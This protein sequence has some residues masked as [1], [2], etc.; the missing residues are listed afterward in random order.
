MKWNSFTPLILRS[1]NLLH[2]LMPE[3]CAFLEN[4]RSAELYR[5]RISRSGFTLPLTPQI[6]RSILRRFVIDYK[7]LALVETGTQYGDTPWHFRHE[8]SEIYSI[9]FHPGLA[10]I[11]RERFRCFPHIHIVE[12]D[13]GGKLVEILPKLE[14]K[15]L[16]WL[17]GHYSA[18]TTA[19]GKL[20]CPIYAELQSIFE[21]CRVPYVVLIDDARCFGVDKDYPTIQELESFVMKSGPQLAFGITN[22]VIF[23]IPQSA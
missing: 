14:K 22:D 4:V 3:L 1:R 10:A 23:I 2:F 15:T 21:E 18:G 11:S 8:L 7:C 12:G 6:K 19:Q 13:S 16:F 9:A 17:D 5:R 20:D